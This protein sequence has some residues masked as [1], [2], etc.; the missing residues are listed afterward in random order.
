MGG[1]EDAYKTPLSVIVIDDMERLMDY[2]QIGPRFSNTILQAFFSLLKKVPPKAKS[3]TRVDGRILIIGTTSN[4]MFMQESELISAFSVALSVPNLCTPEHFK[5]VLRS[6]PG[7]QSPVVEEVANEM[8]GKGLGIRK[9]LLVAEMAVQRQNPVTK[10]IFF[11][12][13]Q[14]V[15][16][17]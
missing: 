5:M 17:D 14:H 8:L 15:G 4:K 2:V 9:L 6:L 13:L 11:E 10:D 16:C 7:F 3:G 12:C 1:F